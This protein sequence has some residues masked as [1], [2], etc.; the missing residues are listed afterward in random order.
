MKHSFVIMLLLFACT[1]VFAQQPIMA[2]QDL[3]SEYNRYMKIKKAGVAGIVVFGATWLAGELICV[4]EQ[5]LYANDR[6]DGNDVKEYARL[7]REA[8]KQPSYKRGVAMEIVGCVGT[9][10]SIFLT[11][12]YGA[13]A[14]RILN[15]QGDVVASLG[16]D[17]GPQGASLRLTF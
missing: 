16:M 10:I 17:L 2:G 15:A 11:A 8:T 12:K 5:N 1:S 7:S 3:T 4:T 6:W 14:K 9:G 13:R